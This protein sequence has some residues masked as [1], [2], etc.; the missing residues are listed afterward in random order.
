MQAHHWLTLVVA[1]VAGIALQRYTSV[2]S[3]VGLP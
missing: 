3:K 1:I 2:W